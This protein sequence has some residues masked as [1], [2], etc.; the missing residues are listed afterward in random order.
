VRRAADSL[1]G[2]DAARLA[3]ERAIL[4]AA[5]AIDR[6]IDG[7]KNHER[8]TAARKAIGV[9][10]EVVLALDA[11]IGRS[12]RIRSRAQALSAQAGTLIQKALLDQRIRFSTR[13]PPAHERIARFL[14]PLA[15]SGHTVTVDAPADA[16]TWRIEIEK[17]GRTSSFRIPKGAASLEWEE[18]VRK[19]LRQ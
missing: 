2:E 4:D 13:R 15:Q 11:E 3:I 18:A 16:D 7:P 9:A 12:L 8:L 17:G 6:T 19:A 14:S 1:R 5:E 10:I